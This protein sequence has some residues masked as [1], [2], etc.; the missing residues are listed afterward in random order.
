M[1]GVTVTGTRET[2]HR[3]PT[4]YADLFTSYLG[5]FAT[6]EAHFY[7]GGATGIDSLAVLWLA[8]NTKS[9]ITVVVPGTI[10]EQPADARQAIGQSRDRL[11]SVV[12]LAAAS[13]QT[14]AYHARNRWMVDR[15]E[16]V[17]GF[18][19]EGTGASGTWYTINYAAEQSKPR[20]VVPV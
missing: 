10:A 14:S 18:P 13:L 7:V 11:T 19:L 12:E 9:G 4:W 1:R 16:L 2:S 17:I 5:P 6:D 8:G 3:N 20:L 15:S